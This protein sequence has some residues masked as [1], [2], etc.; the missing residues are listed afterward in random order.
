MM[1][2]IA[3]VDFVVVMLGPKGRDNAIFELG[4]ARARSRSGGRGAI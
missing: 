2:L 1:R 4:F 3:S